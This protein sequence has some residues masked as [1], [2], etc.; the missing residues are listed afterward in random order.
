M[1]DFLDKMRDLLKPYRRGTAPLEIRRAI[2]DEVQSRIVT[3]G[4]GKRIFPY[5]RI[6]IHILADTPQERE[7]LETIVHE[8]WDLKADIAERLRDH[9]AKAPAD[10]TVE[11]AEIAVIAAGDVPDPAFSG[12]RFRLELQKAESAQAAPPA[13]PIL[14]LTVLKGTASQHVYTFEGQDR[15]NLGRLD[16]VFDAEERV[17]RR[18]DVIF[19]EEGDVSATV[20]REQARLSWDDE[21]KAYRLR[22]EPGAS[23]TRILR[24]GRTIDV[25]PQDRRG[26]KVQHG[27]EIYLGRACV[28][29]T[30]RSIESPS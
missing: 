28:K 13:R 8:G 11:I 22:A 15:I 27:D 9:E 12:R 25:S 26:I 19:L 3:A 10:L 7:E 5:N 20:S 16:E 21:I 29:A 18:N 30:L 17:R 6:K 4:V 24:D 23:V 1:A 14:D 2:L